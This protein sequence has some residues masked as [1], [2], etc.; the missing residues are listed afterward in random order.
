M[1]VRKNP[2]TPLA[3]VVASLLAG[4]AGT[5]CLD[6]VHSLKY[7]RAG[8]TDSSLAWEFAPVEN[9]ETAPDP[10]QVAKRVLEGFTQ[11]KLPDRSAWLT[12]TI[13]HWAYGSAAGAAYGILAGSLPS[14]HPRYGVPFGAGVRRRLYRPADPRALQAD[15]GVRRQ[16]PG[17]GPQRSPRLR[18]GHRNHV[19]AAEQDRTGGE[20]LLADGQRSGEDRSGQVSPD[21]VRP[22]AR[23]LG[24]PPRSMGVPELFAAEIR[25]ALR[26]LR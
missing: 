10:G 14:P 19:L 2:M 4:A 3:A 6:A 5:V 21:R 26:S 25:M 11:R 24:K 18:R 23:G 20:R 1:R 9:W 12:S 17:L 22:R 8:G 15:L 13:A 7:H 16:D